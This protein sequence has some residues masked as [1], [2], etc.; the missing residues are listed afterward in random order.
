MPN[1]T[2][3]PFLNKST[4]VVNIIPDTKGTLSAFFD[5]PVISGIDNY[6]DDAAATTA[7]LVTNSL[8]FNT[9]NNAI[10]KI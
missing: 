3:S 5:K 1:T 9:T 8:Y 4:T 10:D 7:G 2:L 6:V